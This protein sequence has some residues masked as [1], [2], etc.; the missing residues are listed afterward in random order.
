MKFDDFKSSTDYISMRDM[1]N[2]MI[3]NL[4]RL[5]I[6]TPGV[7]VNTESDKSIQ[8]ETWIL[9]IPRHLPTYEALEGLLTELL[10]GLLRG[11][12][13]KL[14]RELCQVSRPSAYCARLVP[15]RNR[16]GSESL[17]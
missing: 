4:M 15:M 3:I 14:L 13:G 9:R 11:L 16:V 1:V 8:S 17:W 7:S 6:D 5:P 2:P 10:G 12:L